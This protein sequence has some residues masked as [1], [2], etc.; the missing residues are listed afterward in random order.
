MGLSDYEPTQGLFNMNR[1]FDGQRHT[2]AGARGMVE[3]VLDDPVND[4]VRRSDREYAPR[5][6]NLRDIHDAVLIGMCWAYGVDPESLKDLNDLYSRLDFNGSSFDPVAAA[7]NAT[8][9][10]E[11]RLGIYPNVEEPLLRGSN[12]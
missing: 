3:L 6:I 5:A 1:P 7:Q 10:I 11:K 4:I 9:E 12:G 8:V 2:D